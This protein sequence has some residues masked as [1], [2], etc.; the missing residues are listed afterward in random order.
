M[1]A[2]YI[3][4]LDDASEYMDYTKWTPYFELFDQYKI[5]PI[6]AV[7]PFNKD[8]KMLNKNPD[9]SF[10]NKVRD[11][12]NKGYR[13]AMHGYEHV[14]STS[15][16]GL[17]GI[18]KRSEFAGIPLEKQIEMLSKSYQ[19]F[20]DEKITPEI[21][22]APAHSFDRNTIRALK[23]ATRIRYISDGYYLNVI[24]KDGLNWIPQQLW[25]P[26]EKT[27]G[28]W[29]LCYHPETSNLR[30]YEEVSKFIQ[31]HSKGFTDPLSLS[32]SAIRASDWL[33]FVQKKIKLKLKDLFVKYCRTGRTA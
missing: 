14:Y 15:N 31:K 6:I 30:H 29:T 26:K 2:Q 11:W 10:W 32:V 16:S 27:K 20:V 22:V 12:H 28:V 24:R 5:I 18:N 3:I 9:C 23:R 13:I 4:R 17:V 7:I 33:Y 25:E 1:P 8:P 19:K 21:F